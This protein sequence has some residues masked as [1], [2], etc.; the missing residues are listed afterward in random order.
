MG[1]RNRRKRGEFMSDHFWETDNYNARTF[2][3]NL[4]MLLSLALNR[5]RWVNLPDTC[6]SRY[7]EWVLHR[8]GIAT[9]S[10][11]KEQPTRIY[12]TLQAMPY[13]AYNMYGLPTQWRAVGYDGLTDYECDN[14]NGTLCYYSN[15]RFSPWN[16]L[17]IYARKMA[18]YERT[19]DVN[20]SQQMKPFIGIAPQEKKLELVNLLKQIEGGEPAILGDSGLL[21]LVNKVTV[22]DTKVP[23]ITE[24]LARSHQNVLNQALLFL[25][26]PHLAFE[27]GER[28]IEDEA[29][30]NTAPTNVM[31]LDCLKARRDFCDKVNAKFDL[32]IHVY[33]NEDLE[34]YNFNYLNNVEQMA[35]DG[36]MENGEGE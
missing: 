18:H 28:M 19:E 25:G 32:D 27:K 4:D 3:K 15:S 34:S 7:L 22:I 8:N 24:E 26:I 12:T 16:A 21:D 2:Q 36:Y 30:A 17:E 20:L 33:F 10:F 23:I 31:L 35:Q 14:E 29:R 11:D 6:D 13:G 9:L 1:K 5:F